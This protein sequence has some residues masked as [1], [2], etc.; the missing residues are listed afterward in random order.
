MFWTAVTT[1]L[2]LVSAIVALK[3]VVL[4]NVESYQDDIISR[5]AA[6]SGMDVSAFAIRGSWSG[7]RPFV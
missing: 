7:F 2:L 1:A 6:S 5:V 4:P 3:Y